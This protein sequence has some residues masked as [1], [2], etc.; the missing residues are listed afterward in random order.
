MSMR[1]F[2][3]S[4]LALALLSLPG[5]ASAKETSYS[6]VIPKVLS[7]PTTTLTFSSRSLLFYSQPITRDAIHVMF[8]N[9]NWSATISDV[10]W[11][12]KGSGTYVTFTCQASSTA[13]IQATGGKGSYRYSL[14]P[15][16]AT[17]PSTAGKYALAW[18]VVPPGDGVLDLAYVAVPEPSTLVMLGTGLLA[19]WGLARK[20]L[21]R[22]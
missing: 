20:K 13:C 4:I 11:L 22:G 17:A 10:H 8:D 3:F 5:A 16:T 15:S 21:V 9:A 6:V 2:T 12:T 19:V 14:L 1:A 7:Y 18:D